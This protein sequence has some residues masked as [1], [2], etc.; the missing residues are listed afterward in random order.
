MNNT[1][2]NPVIPMS[3]VAMIFF[4]LFDRITGVTI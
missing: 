4:S 3:V 1:P 2:N